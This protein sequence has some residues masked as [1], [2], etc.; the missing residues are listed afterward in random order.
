MPIGAKSSIGNVFDKIIKATN[1][2]SIIKSPLLL[3]IV[4]VVMVLAIAYMFIIDSDTAKGDTAKGDTAKGDTTDNLSGT[5]QLMKFGFYS[6][7][8]VTVLLFAH[9]H[10]IL[11]DVKNNQDVGFA[12]TLRDITKYPVSSQGNVAVNP[13]VAS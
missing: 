1:I 6:F 8:G 10:L 4:I 9:N 3:A 7:V 13:M 2:G 11:K 5:K 12:A